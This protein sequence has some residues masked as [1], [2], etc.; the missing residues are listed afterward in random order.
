M[1]QLPCFQ[2]TCEHIASIEK[3]PNAILAK[4]I[5]YLAYREIM[6]DVVQYPELPTGLISLHIRIPKYDLLFTVASTNPYIVPYQ[7][8]TAL[9]LHRNQNSLE[10]LRM[11]DR[12]CEKV[13]TYQQDTI[14]ASVDLNNLICKFWIMWP[15]KCSAICKCK[16]RSGFPLIDGNY[17]C[18]HKKCDNLVFKTDT[19]FCLHD[20]AMGHVR[21]TLCKLHFD[22]L[23][24][25]FDHYLYD[26]EICSKR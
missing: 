8:H 3:E 15:C 7:I 14:S 12:Y 4:R 21:C 25:L 11:A 5:K 22:T 20:Q 24:D 17:K 10:Y 16:A 6:G 18:Y 9:Y 13:I 1:S 26:A 19:E 2:D 23:A